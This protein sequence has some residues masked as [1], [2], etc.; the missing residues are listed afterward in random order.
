[1]IASPERAISPA[2]FYSA[3][4]ASSAS[5]LLF[6]RLL[7]AGLWISL[8]ISAV[9]QDNTNAA[10]IIVPVPSAGHDYIQALSE[11]VNPADGAVSFRIK[12]PV[13]PGRGRATFP[14][15][16][17]YDTN[18]VHFPV[19]NPTGLTWRTN[20]PDNSTFASGGWVYAVPLFSHQEITT[21]V[22]V[23]GVKKPCQNFSF[24]FFQDGLGGRHP[25]SKLLEEPPGQG[26]EQYCTELKGS[27]SD[28]FLQANLSQGHPGASGAVQIADADGTITTGNIG[29]P[30]SIEDRNGNMVLVSATIGCCSGPFSVTDTLGRTLLSSSGFGSTGNTVSVSGLGAAYTLTWGTAA[31]NFGSAWTNLLNPGAPQECFVPGGESGTQPVVTAIQLPNRQQYAFTY[32]PTYGEI[33]K[34]TYPS[35]G[36][37][38]YTWSTNPQ[39]EVI[40]FHS[41]NPSNSQWDTALDCAARYDKP[42]ITHRYVSFDGSNIALQQD[43]SYSTTWDTTT[44]ERWDSKQTRVTTHDL[45]RG[46]SFVTT[47]TYQ[48]IS[49]G[50]GS[51]YFTGQGSQLPAEQTITY[52]DIN[53]A[54]LETVQ[55]T[56][57]DQYEMKSEQT[58]L[59]SGQSALVTYT[60]G[61]GAQV[62]EKDEY[63]FGASTPTRKTVTNY[64]SFAP[65]PIFPTAVS[66]FDR[67][68]QT[69]I[70]DGSNNRYA[71]T[72]YYYDN[73]TGTV[74]VTGT[75]SVTGV[76]NL[77][78]H[79]EVNY[80]LSS[81][82]PRGNLTRKTQWLSTG[83]SPV[84]SYT[85]DET[86]QALSMTDPCGNIGCSDMTGTTHTTNYSYSDS[87]TVL[88]GG[89][90]VGY[91]P[92]GNTNAYLTG[93]TDALGHTQGFTYDYNNGQLTVSTDQ[94]Q[95]TT[96][97][98][99]GDQFFDRI[100]Q[101][102][103]PD[104]GQ[105]QYSYND[106]PYNASTP[107]PSITT[108][109][110]I[111]PGLN[112]V[113]I[114][115]FDGMGHFVE[116]ILSS[117]PDGTTYTAISYDG[118]ARQYQIYNPTHC[119]PPTIN[120]E[121]LSPTI[122]GFS[123][124]TYDAL[125][126]TT[127]VIKPDGSSVATTYS[128]NRTTVTD[129][130]GNQRTSQNDALGRLTYVWEAS[131]NIGYNF[132]TD[133]VYDTLSN[134]LSVNQKGG[135]SNSAN[136]RTRT[137]TYDSLSRLLCTANPEVQLVTCP[138]SATGTFPSG[139]V[140]FQYDVNG[141]LSS[142]VAPKPGQTGTST[143]TTNYSYDVLNRMLQ[144][145][146]TGIAT[147]AAIY[148]YDGA[149]LTG[150]GQNPP[151]I[152]SPTNLVGRRSAM[153]SGA[154]GSSWS[155]DPMGRTLVEARTNLAPGP[156]S[157]TYM[158]G[159]T[160]YQEGSLNTL[161]YPSG[162]ILYY[163][164]GGAGRFTAAGDSMNIYAT[165]ATYIANGSL[166]NVL[167]GY[168]NPYSPGIV[169]EYYYNKRL[170]PITHLAQVPGALVLWGKCY[171]FHLP[172]AI[173]NGVCRFNSSTTGDN[174]NVFEI[175]D[176]DDS[177]RDVV[178]SYDPL[179]RLLQANTT[180]TTGANCWGE[181]YTI[182]AWG[183]LT[184]RA[185]VSGMTGCATEGLN[186][187]PASSQNR[188]NGP[189]YDA[190]GNVVNDGNGNQPTYDA[191]NRITTDA[192]VTY[193]YDGNGMRIEKS[194]GTM[195]WPSAN[196]EILM[197]TDLTGT[198]NEEYV[199]FN[200]KR[201][202]RVDRPSGA[203]RYYFSDNLGSASLITDASF[204][205]QEQNY[206]Y[207]YGGLVS[208]TGSDP[209][210]YKFTGK[211]RDAESGLDE[212][213]ARYYASTMGRFMIPDWSAAPTSVPYA[214]LPYPQSLNL[215]SYVQN[216]PLSRTDPD[217]HCDVDGEHH[218]GLWCAAHALG[219]T[220][221]KEE[222]A[223][224]IDY[225]LKHPITPAQSAALQGENAAVSIIMI[226]MAARGS[227]AATD[228]E[229][230]S[231]EATAAQAAEDAGATGTGTART[232][233]N[234]VPQPVA[235][236]ETVVGPG[237]TA[238]QIPAGYVAEPA[239]NGNGIVYRPAGS[240]GDA[241]TIRVMGPD[242][243]GRY[244]QG[245]VRIYNSSGQPVVPSTGKPG[246]QATTHSPL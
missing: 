167:L 244:P 134:L 158:V 89:S 54:L 131:N 90:N 99:Y 120:C 71:E 59:S 58:T 82:A 94:N 55:K 51:N 149:T 106:S 67:P 45:V 235:A 34:V 64:Q 191:E 183:N 160:Y 115:A 234:G 174:G 213:G 173:N 192:G 26:A 200:G 20:F 57:Y 163:G 110:A 164:L 224:R 245:Y 41:Y 80:G 242:A 42:A 121:G 16:F 119:N 61:P 83:T 227:Q 215:Y 40:Y 155:F 104:G 19:A 15:A 246:S 118:G 228:E 189:L 18:G 37:I 62:T 157:K 176:I 63:D 8:S 33:N 77:T 159:Y 47:Y 5:C 21:S 1:M 225:A 32:D 220:E 53:G 170:Q 127:R 44:P 43:F 233:V 243:Q 109:K 237:G 165:G 179:N 56:W 96:H 86:G 111:A 28:D 30:S 17:A 223:A 202:A 185:G 211:E 172:Y 73:G 204:N 36:Y 129:E 154:S 208:S 150:C 216:N 3:R 196:G 184:N 195:Y 100:T 78:G 132:E 201:I 125:G 161:T 76:S 69:I 230:A 236:G 72:D 9:A 101:V 217:G 137:F 49:V 92:D 126:R 107:S 35:G 180:N 214:S 116:N 38:S 169:E 7:V 209:N 136:W 221:T 135:T 48:P 25:F 29:L 13:P 138:A 182:D 102:N 133:Y 144:K 140:I 146:Y 60:Y 52:N 147:P 93:V 95:K 143:V 194:S 103:Y 205:I 188:L 222:Y 113:N 199:Y 87:Y 178:Y 123:S 177:T 97:Y 117:D 193:S 156:V 152:S 10:D 81:T 84:T 141:N 186:A 75:P 12:V 27:D 190:A 85:Y 79:D 148:G 197:E 31:S 91:T 240:T 142:R 226:G 65:T 105:T 112:E 88:S 210:R 108:T 74:C 231:A 153:C 14:F 239:A 128:G 23:N 98:L 232:M 50:P 219:F 114:N 139:A 124:Y 22:E 175:D 68:C 46:I 229:L 203:V 151:V 39:S 212:F 166:N 70:Y 171:D 130:I 66:I 168:V 4:F 2:A 206:Y 181:V 187:A 6:S 238:V 145:S 218:G 241:N 122:W 162:N 24:Y 11:T 207:P 198:I